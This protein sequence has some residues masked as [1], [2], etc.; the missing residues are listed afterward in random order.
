MALSGNKGEWSEFLVFLKV[1][2]E[3]RIYAADEDLNRIENM[4][5]PVMSVIRKDVAG[6]VDY[7]IHSENGGYVVI[8]VDDDPV[9]ITVARNELLEAAQVLYEKVCIGGNGAFEVPEM[10]SIMDRLLCTRI[11]APAS[12]KTDIQMTVHDI[13][14]G[15]DKRVGF[16]IKSEL[17]HSPTLLNASKATNFVY[18]IEGLADT[19]VETINEISGRT[20]ILDRIRS[21]FEIGSMVYSGMNNDT[22]AGNLSLI[23]TRMDE[24]V[25]NALLFYYRENASTCEEVVN[26][27]ENENPLK[28]SRCGFYEYKFK[29]FLCSVAL[30]MVPSKEWDGRDEANGGYI[31]VNKNG[32]IVT[33]HIYNRDLFEDYLLKNTKFERGSTT[34][35][36]YASIYKE[37]DNYYMKLNLQIRFK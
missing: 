6:I 21:I 34:R 31:I 32:E 4:Y 24:L 28:V 33:Y 8:S 23:D 14:T 18:K 13:Q 37:N 17:G 1:L 15:Y 7:E 10:N 25:A 27:L 19:D 16:S 22:F 11:A 9:G 12:D 26:K 3:G 29:K 35:H 20:K 2:A 36:D 30:G 5:Y